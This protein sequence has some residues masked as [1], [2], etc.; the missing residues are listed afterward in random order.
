MNTVSRSAMALIAA[1]LFGSCTSVG[2]SDRNS[3]NAQG[4]APKTDGQFYVQT[5]FPQGELSSDAVFPSIQIQFSEPVVALK[6]LGEPSST[7]NECSL[8]CL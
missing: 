8:D 1:A 6:K 5:V 3:G 7:S 2:N 4:S